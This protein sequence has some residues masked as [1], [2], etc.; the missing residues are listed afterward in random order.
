M[1]NKVSELGSR[2]DRVSDRLSE[3]AW[4]LM[5]VFFSVPIWL[6]LMALAAAWVYEWLRWRSSKGDRLV[7]GRVTVAERPVR[8]VIVVMFLLAAAVFIGW[9]QVWLVMAMIVWV[10]VCLIGS[11][12]V[13]RGF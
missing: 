9:A 4:L 7:T 8:V 12:Q 13:T 11:W 5:F 10:G 2:L 1:R 3:M 6:A